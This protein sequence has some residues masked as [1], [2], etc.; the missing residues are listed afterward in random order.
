MMV[1]CSL[2]LWANN[3]KCMHAQAGER[4]C[5]GFWR[6]HERAWVCG[7]AAEL[8]EVCTGCAG[9][10]AAGQAGTQPGWRVSRLFP[11]EVKHAHRAVGGDRGKD[12]DAAPGNVVHLA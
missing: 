3:N 6:G 11:P 5:V 10:Q 8:A 7:L 4:A 9:G 12:P 2:S 1:E